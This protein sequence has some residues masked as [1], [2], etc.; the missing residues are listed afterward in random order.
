MDDND[1][2]LAGD[3]PSRPAR[4]SKSREKV[5]TLRRTTDGKLSSLSVE[6]LAHEGIG[7]EVHVLRNGEVF[8]TEMC[9]TR[10][11]AMALADVTHG[12]ARA[13]GWR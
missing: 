7:V 11:A 2:M 1:P 5:W 10:T 13:A 8:T 12:A 3:K 4:E 6:L 9:P